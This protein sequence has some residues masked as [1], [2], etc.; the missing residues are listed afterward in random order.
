MVSRQDL[1]QTRTRGLTRLALARDRHQSPE[2]IKTSA[3]VMVSGSGIAA[4]GGDVPSPV[5]DV[6]SPVGANTSGP[7]AE[8]G[9]SVDAEVDEEGVAG[10]DVDG[11]GVSCSGSTVEPGFEF[12]VTVG[13]VSIASSSRPTRG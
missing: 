6:P 12:G 7:V 8:G 3:M 2:P 13:G 9:G 4:G 11:G 10:V 5:G 1:G